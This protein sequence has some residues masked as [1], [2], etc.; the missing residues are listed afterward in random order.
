[1]LSSSVIISSIIGAFLRWRCHA[2][3]QM[4]PIVAALPSID[5]FCPLCFKAFNW[6]A[7]ML[8][9][10]MRYLYQY[11]TVFGFDLRDETGLIICVIADIIQQPTSPQVWQQWPHR[12]SVTKPQSPSSPWLVRWTIEGVISAVFWTRRSQR[13]PRESRSRV[14]K[15]I[16]IFK[17]LLRGGERRKLRRGVHSIWRHRWFSW[18]WW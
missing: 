3:V 4:E 2:C 16:C 9:R 6:K 18:W 14:A 12:Q 13:R 10:S 5:F 7:S 1:M 11:Q 17:S 15:D 8:K